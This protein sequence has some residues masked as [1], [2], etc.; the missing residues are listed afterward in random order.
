M[1]MRGEA[2]GVHL[3]SNFLYVP[4][5]GSRIIYSRIDMVYR[6]IF[7]TVPVKTL[8]REYCRNTGS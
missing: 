4:A 6:R 8:Q 2:N 7:R 1:S 3:V 5:L